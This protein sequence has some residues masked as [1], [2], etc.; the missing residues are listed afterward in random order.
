LLQFHGNESA[1][2]CQ[3]FQRP[4]I[5]AL[6]IHQGKVMMS[7]ELFGRQQDEAQAAVKALNPS[8]AAETPV[9]A[10][11][12]SD[13]LA[14]YADATGFLFDTYKPG[15]PG[16]TGDSFDWAEIPARLNC[17]VILAGGLC[18]ENVANAISVLAPFAV[19][20]SSGVELEPGIKSPQR[21]RAFF[22]ALA[23]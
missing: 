7:S 20:V 6:R 5:K 21:M 11:P 3:S 10:Y 18:A 17:P 23:P 9:K 12:I 22:S 1:E 19:D 8:S 2:F 14:H 13:V 15:A 4:Y 16:G